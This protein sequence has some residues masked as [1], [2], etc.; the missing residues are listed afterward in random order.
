[1]LYALLKTLSWIASHTPYKL[2]VKIG[3]G[4]GH[5]YWHI[6]K[7]QR[8]RAEETIRKRLG[9]S[10]YEANRTIKRLFVNLGISV[11]EMLY[12]P[13]LN[14]DNI[15]GLVTFDHPEILWEALQQ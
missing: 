14:K 7:K 9:Y 5:L 10:K 8:I 2:L 3:T 1:M 12:M 13:A 4:L 15:R 6:A 11:M